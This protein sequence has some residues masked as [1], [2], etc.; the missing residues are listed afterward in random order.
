MIFAYKSEIVGPVILPVVDT[1]PVID[2]LPVGVEILP[3][4]TPTLLSVADVGLVSVM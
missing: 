3:V 1:L 4:V 2:K